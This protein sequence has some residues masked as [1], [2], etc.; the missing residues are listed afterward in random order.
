MTFLPVCPPV[1]SCRHGACGSGNYLVGPSDDT[2]SFLMPLCTCQM[3]TI[4]SSDDTSL[5]LM[6]LCPGECIIQF[7]NCDTSR[8]KGTPITCKDINSSRSRFQGASRTWHQSEPVKPSCVNTSAERWGS[9][10]CGCTHQ[11]P[12]TEGAGERGTQC[13]CLTNQ[14]TSSESRKEGRKVY[15]TPGSHSGLNGRN[16]VC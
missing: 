15:I 6:P 16:R 5:T 9:L 4:H 3:Q 11:H 2:E 1:Q 7:H 14:H 8:D 10:A 13:I 12:R